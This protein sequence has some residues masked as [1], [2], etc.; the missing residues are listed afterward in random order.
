MLNLSCLYSVIISGEE[1]IIL[2]GGRTQD[3]LALG[4]CFSF[5]TETKIWT[6][7]RFYLTF[8]LHIKYHIQST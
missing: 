5:H 1:R 7:V 2:F 6:K 3:V 8:F 4:D